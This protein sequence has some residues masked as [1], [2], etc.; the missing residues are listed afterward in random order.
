VEPAETFVYHGC[1][2][3]EANGKASTLVASLFS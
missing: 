1:C 3:A 2:L